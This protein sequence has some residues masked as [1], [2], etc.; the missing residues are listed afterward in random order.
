MHIEKNV[1]VS[2]IRTMSN[3]KGAKADSLAVRQELEARNMMPALHPK[4]TREVDRDGKTI[5]R[6]A[7]PAP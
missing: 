7:K 4:S 5:Y 2:M 6:Y 3:A 1:I